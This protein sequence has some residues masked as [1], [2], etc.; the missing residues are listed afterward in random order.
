MVLPATCTSF[1]VRLPRFFQGSWTTKRGQIVNS[2]PLLQSERPAVRIVA[3]ANG[4][5]LSRR[6]TEL[7]RFVRPRLAGIPVKRHGRSRDLDGIGGSLRRAC[8]LQADLDFPGATDFPG[9]RK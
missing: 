9:I 3:H 7:H 1:S 5:A 8:G 6:P 4:A 2:T